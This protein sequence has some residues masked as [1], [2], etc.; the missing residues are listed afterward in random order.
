M[1]SKTQT[2]VFGRAAVQPRQV[3]SI[4]YRLGRVRA[5]VAGRTTATPEITYEWK[6]DDRRT[7]C[8]GVKPTRV[9]LS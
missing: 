2:C 7:D 1:K 6:D 4:E 9:K 3:S 8:C 5:V